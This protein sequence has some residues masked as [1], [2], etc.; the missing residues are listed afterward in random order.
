VLLN[1]QHSYIIQRI[2]HYASFEELLSREDPA[3]IAPG[4][5]APELL[6][7]LRAIYPADKEALGVVALEI[8]S[9]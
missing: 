7:A 2:G 4:M 8:R 6:N 9:E 1:G 3:S 5:T